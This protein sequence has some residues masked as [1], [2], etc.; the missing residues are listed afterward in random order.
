V[1]HVALVGSLARGQ[2]RASSD[3][4]VLITPQEDR[5]LSLFD[6]GAVQTLL[7]SSFP[8]RRVDVLVAPIRRPDIREA[9][10]RDSV[11]AF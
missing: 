11:H 9:V 2:S 6:L 8:G 4:D 5:K 7:E 10:T 3:I 1:Q